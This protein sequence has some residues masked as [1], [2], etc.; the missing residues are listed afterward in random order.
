MSKPLSQ[1]T[2]VPLAGFR[3][4]RS[5]DPDQIVETTLVLRRTSTLTDDEVLKLS[6]QPPSERKYLTSEQLAGYGSHPEDIAKVVEFAHEHGLAVV[7]QNPTARTVKLSGTVK[8]L[9]KA[10]GVDL[11]IYEDATGSRSYRGR[12][13]EIHIPDELED[14]VE[15]V[16]GLDNRDQAKPHFRMSTHGVQPRLASEAAAQPRTSAATSFNPGQVAA[17]YGFP[18]G[19]TGKGQTIALIELGGG[20][21][22]ADLKKYFKQQKANPKVSAVSVHGATNHPTGDPNG[23]DGEVELDIEVAG[24]IAS[25]ANIVVYFAHNTDKGFLDAITA[26]I[27]DQ[28]HR[29]SIVSISW[30]GRES[31][32]TQQSMDAFNEV[33]KDAAMLGVTVLVASGDDGSSDGA[34]DGADHVDFPASSPFVLACG[35][36]R[37]I[38][39]GSTITKETTWGG[40]PNNGASGGGVSQHFATPSYQTGIVPTNFQGRGVPDVA[41]D[42]DP[43]TGYN[44]LV[45]GVPSVIGGT[46]AVAPL[47][48]AL[49][50]QINEK[51]G[52]KCGFLNPV[53]YSTPGICNDIVQGTNGT[54]NAATGWDATTGLGSIQGSALL[55]KLSTKAKAKGAGTAASGN[56]EVA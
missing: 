8:A 36:T 13:G 45:D 42:A 15:S 40:I 30:G 52:T 48:A 38:A 25:S 18:A 35:G 2:R 55:G 33:F 56:K 54:F 3:A 39:N 1:S 12:T 22:T 34:S 29:P 46:S 28:K 24:S 4:V 32:W 9:Q 41:G 53:L 27:H 21:P 11:K 14:V 37:L 23:P 20:Y 51:T 16:H 49:V 31:S 17:A 43:Q 44:V 50:A 26:A 47:Y 6:S 5:A 10:F 7:D 19:A